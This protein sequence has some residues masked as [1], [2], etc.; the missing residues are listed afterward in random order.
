MTALR[1]FGLGRVVKWTV[2]IL[3]LAA[4]V[5]SLAFLY[6]VPPFDATA[7]EEYVR[8]EAAAAAPVTQVKDGVT[9]LIA[10][11]G[12]YIVM[13]S[14]CTG[15]HVTPGPR[16]LVY[17]MYMAGGLKMVHGQAGTAVARNLTPDADTGLGKWTDEEIKLVL[18]TGIRP[19]GRQQFHRF[20]PWPVMS[21]WSEE[22]RHA[23]VVYLRTLKPIRHRIPEPSRDVTLED[24]GAAEA[25][26][27]FDYG[28]R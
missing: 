9:R 14:G 16:G 28:T 12:R 2:L 3:V 27:R 8:M 23:V 24:D 20:M 17:D 6:F 11:R 1:R 22:D 5:G 15:C 25:F 7:P 26:Y 21:R 10:E 19:D 18:R 13:T 4:F